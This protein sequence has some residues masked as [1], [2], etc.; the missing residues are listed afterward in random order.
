MRYP[1]WLRH[2]AAAKPPGAR[3]PVNQLPDSFCQDIADYS[4]V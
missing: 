2:A 1:I 3:E 4:G